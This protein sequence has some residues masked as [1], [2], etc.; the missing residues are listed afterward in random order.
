MRDRYDPRMAHDSPRGLDTLETPALLVERARLERNLA[1]MQARAEALGVRL[2]PHVKTHKSLALGRR[3]AELGAR[4]ITVST[5]AEADHFFAG[6]A[7]DVLYAACI[8]P[9]KLAHALRLRRAGCALIVVVDSVAAARAVAEYGRAQGERFAVAL[10]IDTDDHRAGLAPDARELPEVAAALAGGGAE[11]WGVM[12]HAGGSYALSDAAALRAFAER[13]RAGCVHAAERLRAAGHACREV[14]VGSTPTALSAATLAGVTELRAGVYVFQDLVM[15][16]IGV[17]TREELALSVLTSV[18]GHQRAK[19][20]VLVDA[21]WL[22]MS[23]D[24]GTAGQ[25]HDHG[26]GAVATLDGRFLAELAFRDANQEHGIL[27]ADPALDVA[28]RFPV[29]TQLRIFPN[30]AC[31]TA[32]AFPRYHVLDEHGELLPETWDRIH[33]W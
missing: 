33:G 20:W 9:N 22:A 32:A 23:R 21:G 7:R 6:G 12:T 4:G 17:C 15:L 28:A 29:G 18:T 8:A 1:R 11:L 31:A 30:H 2:R 13:E 24:R 16:G 25:A 19:G 5:L 14:S 27:V 10:E 26:Y 3:Q